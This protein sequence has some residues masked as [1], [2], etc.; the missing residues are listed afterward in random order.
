MDDVAR[1]ADEQSVGELHDVRLVNGVDLLASEL[2]GVLKGPARDARGGLFGD[3]LDALDHAGNDLVLD[4]GV[5]SLGVFADDDEID[6]GIAGGNAGKIADGAEVAEEFE[7]LAQLHVDAAESAADGRGDRAF[8]RHAG[9]LDGFDQLLGDV[10][11][12]F[13]KGVGPG[14]I[15]LPLKLDAG[16]FQDS[17][18]RGCNFRTDSV[19]RNQR[20]FMCHSAPI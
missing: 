9:A 6:A 16:G 4:A 17:D 8:Q 7:L 14:R 5:Q 2:A 12:I 1:T 11:V 10:L 18:C 3:D 13:G 15:A 20:N 19:A